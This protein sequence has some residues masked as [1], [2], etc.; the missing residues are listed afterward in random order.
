MMNTMRRLMFWMVAGALMLILFAQVVCAQPPAEKKASIPSEETKKGAKEGEQKEKPAPEV[1]QAA[2][3]R[4]D[5]GQMQERMVTRMKETLA[6]TDE[7]WKT[8]E[9]AAKSLVDVRMKSSMMSG[10]SRRPREGSPAPA[11]PAEVEDLRKALDSEKSTPDEIK[12]K[13]AAYRDMRK[14]NEEE[15]KKAQENLRKVV[16]IKQEARLVLMGYLE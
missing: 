15:M 11:G 4:P 2:V 10:G 12:Q 3:R 9:P 1:G 5:T 6:C 13:L 16:N 14:K 7:E 8:I